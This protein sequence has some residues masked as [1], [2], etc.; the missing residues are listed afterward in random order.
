MLK[1]NQNQ[2]TTHIKKKI[3]LLELF[4]FLNKKIKKILN[5]KKFIKKK[6]SGGK[7]KELSAPKI[8]KKKKSNMIFFFRLIDK[9]LNRSKNFFFFIEHFHIILFLNMIKI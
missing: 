7:L 2:K 3:F 6:L 9:F 4:K 8:N 1:N 5:V